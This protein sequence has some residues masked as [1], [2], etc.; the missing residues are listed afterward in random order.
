M[1]WMESL[2]QECQSYSPWADIDSNPAQQIHLETEHILW[3]MNKL[4][5]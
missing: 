4:N 1:K 3:T 5:E 2:A